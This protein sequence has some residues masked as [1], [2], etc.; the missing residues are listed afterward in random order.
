MDPFDDYDEAP[1]P[2][3]L[4]ASVGILLVVLLVAAIVIGTV[5]A[6]LG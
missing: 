2:R 3:R 6:I 1:R 4:V 5:Q